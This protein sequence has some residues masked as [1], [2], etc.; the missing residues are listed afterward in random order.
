VRE[1]TR[2]ELKYPGYKRATPKHPIREVLA[3]MTGLNVRSIP[4]YVRGYTLETVS[5]EYWDRLQDWAIRHTRPAWLTGIGL[6]EAAE[7]QVKEAVSN[8]NI[9]PA[10]PLPALTLTRKS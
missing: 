9:P 5:D 7:A 1:L 10:P 4:F 2:R 3:A 6:L 8:G